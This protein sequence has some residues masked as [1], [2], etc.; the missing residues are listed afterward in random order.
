M[1]A[2]KELLGSYTPKMIHAGDYPV[3]T[4]SGTVAAGQ[5]IVELMPVELGADGKLKAITSSTIANVYGLAAE[6]KEEGEELVIYLTGQFFGDAL[7]VPAGTTA[8]D[9]KANLRKLGIFLVDT[10]NTVTATTVTLAEDSLGT[11]GNEKITGLTANSKYKITVNGATYAVNA[12]GTVS[13]STSVGF[14]DITA[15]TGTEITGLTNGTTYK[16]EAVTE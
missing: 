8:A 9:F 14:A 1:A 16:V 6:S 11:A 12:D 13:D 5:T 7:V 3:V 2:G 4:D 10:E 15:L